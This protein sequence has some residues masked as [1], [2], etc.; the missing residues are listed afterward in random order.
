VDRLDDVVQPTRREKKVRMHKNLPK[1]NDT[2]YAHFV[3]TRTHGNYPYFRDKSLAKILQEEMEFYA[4]K[5]GFDLLGHVIMPDHLHL[6]VWWDVEAKPGLTISKIM[7]GI[8]GSA[9]RRIIDLVKGSSEHPLRLR[10]EP[11]LSSTPKYVHKQNLRYR[12]W[13]PGFY[14]FNIYSEEKLRGKLDY[15]HD[16][17]VRAGLAP[18]P[19]KYRWSSYR[20]YLDGK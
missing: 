14:D 20:D 5:Y 11:M 2:S 7:Q 3:T 10:R 17:P 4:K 1:F 9:A 13:Q 8:K 12:L 16:N 18:E 19:A 15:M 6:L